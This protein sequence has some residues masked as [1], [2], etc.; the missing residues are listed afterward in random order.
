M[1][2]CDGSGVDP[3]YGNNKFVYDSSDYIK[4]KK[5]RSVNRNYNDRSFGGNDHHG[6]YVARMAV[7]RG[8]S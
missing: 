6:E 8:L 7:H 3:N 5:L 2:L 1:S 4:Y